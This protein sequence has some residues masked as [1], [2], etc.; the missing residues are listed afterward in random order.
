MRL[1]PQAKAD[2]RKIL[3]WSEEHFGHEAALRYQELIIQALRDLEA[4]PG[5]VGVRQRVDLPTGVY[6][7]DLVASR[8]RVV[9]SK[10]TSP[11][12]IVIFRRLAED[13]F[14]VL[15]ILHDSRDLARHLPGR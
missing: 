9:K 7:Y 2:I 11:R 10:V 12:H 5:R 13:M 3:V 15:R 4:D 8:D 6:S 14:E 1:S